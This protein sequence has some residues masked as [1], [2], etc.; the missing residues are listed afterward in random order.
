MY[1]VVNNLSHQAGAHA[2]RAGVDFL[3]NDDT[4]TYPAL[5]SRQL[6]VLVARQLP[7]RHL[8]QRRLHADVRRDR[9]SRRPTQ[10]GLYAQ[11]EWKVARADAEPRRALRPAVPRDDPHRHQQRVAARRLRLDAV[12]RRGARSCA[13][14]PASSSIACRCARSPTRCCRPATRPTSRSLRQISV[15]LSPDAGRRAGVSRTSSPAPCRRSRSSN[16]TTMDR[17]PAERVLAAG[18]RRGRA[19]DRRPQR[20]SASATSTC[21]GATC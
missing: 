16:L 15:S 5:D 9:S 12:R 2:L 18:E 19:A 3:Y 17:E 14:A 11:D 7:R 1:Q 6:H 8:Q 21:A 20:R 4:I 13:A 10:L